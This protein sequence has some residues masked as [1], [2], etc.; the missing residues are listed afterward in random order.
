[1]IENIGAA[2]IP[3]RPPRVRGL[4]ILGSALNMQKN[5]LAYF[6]RLYEKHGPVFELKVLNQNYTVMAGLEANR[7]LAR[8]GDE[9]LGS[10]VLF[11]GFAK[12]L[13]SEALLTALDGPPHKHQRKIQRRGYSKDVI[14]SH[15]P[16]VIRITDNFTSR[17]TPNARIPVFPTL[18]RIVT[19]QL[20]IL[21]LGRSCGEYFD[22]LWLLLNTVMK[23]TVMKTHPARLLKGRRY[24]QAKAR[25]TG[26]ARDVLTWQRAHPPVDR[27]PNLV[28]DLITGVNENGEPY[29]DQMMITTILGAYFAGMDTVASTASFMLYAIL[30]TPGLLDSL[31]QEIDATFAKGPITVESLRDMH[32]LHNTAMETLRYYPVAAFTPRTVSSPFEFA[33]YHFETGTQVFAANALTHFLPEYFPNPQVFDVDRYDRSD[34]TKVPNAMAP[35]T[36]GAHTCLGAGMAEVQLMLLI[37]AILHKVS[38]QLDPPDYDVTIYA[39]PIPNPGRKFSVRVE[40][41]RH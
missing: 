6:L 4:P 2:P 18:Q 16:D 8:E 11:G 33:G 34:Y 40:G 5:P 9:H 21:V 7:F 20:G 19:E 35:F 31:T 27:A 14:L 13:G 28:D 15:M 30:K 38:L 29:S 26:L 25:A 10:D 3:V 32:V 1:M 17:W 39:S 12:E 23:V 41:Q 22:D 24:L 37:A 36:L